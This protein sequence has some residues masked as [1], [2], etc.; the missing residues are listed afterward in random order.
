MPNFSSPFFRESAPF[1]PPAVESSA[2]PEDAEEIITKIEDLPDGSKVYEIADKLEKLEEEQKKGDFY[3][4]LAEKMPEEVLGGISAKILEGIE[5]DKES[6]AEWE[7]AYLNGLKYCGI[8]LETFKDV[9][10]MTACRAFDTTL[11]TAVVNFYSRMKPLLFPRGGPSS[12]EIL[13]EADSDL[14]DRGSRIQEWLN[15]YLVHKDKD[16]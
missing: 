9:P 13:G 12:Y 10:F 16:Y 1:E 7:Q 2:P 15:Y 14:E 4:N 3:E 11:S 5:Q 6:R 8:K